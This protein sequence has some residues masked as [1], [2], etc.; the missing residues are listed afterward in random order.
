MKILFL[1][2]VTLRLLHFDVKQAKTATTKILIVR[3]L[4][5]TALKIRA[6]TKEGPKKN[7]SNPH[8]MGIKKR[9]ILR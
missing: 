3:A 9:R 5:E 7:F 2:P 6:C 8:M 1:I 4:P